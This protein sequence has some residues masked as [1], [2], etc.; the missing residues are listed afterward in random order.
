MTV[1]SAGALL[2]QINSHWYR[3]HNPIDPPIVIFEDD[4]ETGTFEKWTGTLVESGTTLQVVAAAAHHGDYGAQAICPGG[5]TWAYA[6][7]DFADISPV[8]CRFYVRADALPTSDPDADIYRHQLCVLSAYTTKRLSICSVSMH[9]DAGVGK[10][11][12]IYV[13]AGVSNLVY[14]LGSWALNTWHSVEIMAKIGATDGEAAL[15]V[16]GVQLASYTGLDNNDQGDV[17]RV[18]LG[19]EFT[20]DVVTV[21]W[22]CVSVQDV[23]IGPEVPPPVPGVKAMFGGLYLVFPA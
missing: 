20:R 14:G 17:D 16:D 1:L 8:Y 7:K 3:R 11:A 4:F 13:D 23:Y 21:D 5:Y 15:W 10:W 18:V 19:V 6:F 22:D 12:F 9:N 2:H